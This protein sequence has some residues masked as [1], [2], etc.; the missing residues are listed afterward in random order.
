M[1]KPDTKFAFLIVLAFFISGCGVSASIL[2]LTRKK[3]KKDD[4]RMLMALAA[5]SNTAPGVDIVTPNRAGNV[6]VDVSYTLVDLES[7]FC[8]IRIQ[9]SQNGTDWYYA[10]PATGGDGTE[11]LPSSPGG[12]PHVFA[13]NV[14]ADFGNHA[15]ENV[16][17]RITPSDDE[18][19]GEEAL[20][21]G[22]TIGNDPPVVFIP[23]P[24][25]GQGGFLP[26]D[27][28]LTD[29]TADI[30]TLAVEFSAD[31]GNNYFPAAIRLSSNTTLMDGVVPNIVSGRPPAGV[32]GF[33]TWDTE[34]NLPAGFR[35]DIIV[36]VTPSDQFDAG[37]PVTT[38]PFLVSNN[39]PPTCS[40]VTD[41]SGKL[42]SD[43]QAF[44]VK[45]ADSNSDP[46]SLMVF[47]TTDG[48]ATLNGATLLGSYAG[49]STS[50][51][52]DSHPVIWSTDTD[53]TDM[54]DTSVNLVLV[55]FDTEVGPY[56]PSPQFAVDNL[57]PT[58]SAFVLWDLNRD[59]SIDTIDVVMSEPILDNSMLTQ[60]AFI[61]S[62]GLQPSGFDTLGVSD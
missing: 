24:F 45:I 27:Y 26:I 14:P 30:C 52:G 16:L 11:N 59:G 3:D 40:F 50:P 37:N 42:L 39:T 60:L 20:T 48:G 57:D 44:E 22:F 54:E 25:A 17:L 38:A 5:L 55:A 7:D 19:E 23:T 62:A 41:L 49:L 8:S 13:W 10:T 9:F 18:I 53:F 34:K 2:G 6:A 47:F 1:K 21:S 28:L 33:V 32:E 29:T 35:G 31:Y 56:A 36:R 15:A 61:T 51:D 46:A 12:V 43:L 58:V 4:E